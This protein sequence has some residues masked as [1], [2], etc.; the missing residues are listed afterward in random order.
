MP[1]LRCAEVAQSN[2]TEGR[3]PLFSW[4]KQKANLSDMSLVLAVDPMTTL[5]DTQTDMGIASAAGTMRRALR[6][7]QFNQGLE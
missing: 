7:P 5:R 4:T 1:I 3:E 6:S 2:L